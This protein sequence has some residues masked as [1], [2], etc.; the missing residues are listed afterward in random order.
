MITTAT[1]QSWIQHPEEL[2]KDTLYQLR[3]AVER[4]PYF[5]SLRLLFLKNLFLLHDDSFGG[6]L[7]KSIIY[8]SDRRVLFQLLE[9]EQY[10]YPGVQDEKTE[11]VATAEEGGDR[12]LSLIDQIGRAHV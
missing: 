3:T 7:R 4:Y 8:V 12:M 2:N 10:V 1:L 5:E 9:G 11:P 6:E